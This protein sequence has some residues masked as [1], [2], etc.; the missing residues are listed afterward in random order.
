MKKLMVLALL[1]YATSCVNPEDKATGN[2]DSTAFNQT[3]N[4]NNLNT[5]SDKPDNHASDN[6]TSSSPA[7]MKENSNSATDG[8]NR[9]YK[10][11]GDS[12]RKKQ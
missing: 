2:A 1:M 11:G 8:T 3:G 12:N 4:E 5:A 9:G 7:T 10:A 6:D